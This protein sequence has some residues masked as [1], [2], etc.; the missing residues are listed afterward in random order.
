[1]TAVKP[2]KDVDLRPPTPALSRAGKKA[3]DA[4]MEAAK[5]KPN[6]DASRYVRQYEVYG[7]EVTEWI[8]AEKFREMERAKK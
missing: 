8:S 3:A 7:M 4:I 6:V 5:F 2:L 1:M